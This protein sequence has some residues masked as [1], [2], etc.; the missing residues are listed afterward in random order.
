[1]KYIVYETTNLVNNKIYIGI[2][3]TVNPE[4][5]DNYIGCGCLTTQ[6]WTYMHPKTHFQYAVKKYG[7]KNFR[8]KTLAIFDTLEE[9]SN[10]EAELVNEK[11]LQ[12]SD[13]YNMILGGINDNFYATVKCYQYD[14]NGNFIK[15]YESIKQASIELNCN[16]SLI[17]HA[18][19]LKIK[20]KN[21][22]WTNV[23]YDKLDITE[24]NLRLNH[25]VPIYVYTETGE[26]L[27]KFQN[28]IQAAKEIGININSIKE[29]CIFGLLKKGFYFCEVKD[30]NYSKAR[31]TYIENR[32][33]YKYDGTTNKFLQEYK[34]QIDAEKEY[35]D[36]NI[37]KA[38]KLKQLCINNFYW[39]L[40][41]LDLFGQSIKNKKRQ[42]GQYDLS[43]NLL[44]I[45]DSATAAANENGTSVWKVLNGTNKSQKGCVYKYLT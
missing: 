33:I 42:V 11:F 34:H 8:R 15:E 32:P 18:I 20:G 27:T 26:Y 5:F 36:S 9:A 16:H 17:G 37:N 4:V 30:K 19:A 29:A 1:M 10:L 38:I 2:H 40:E 12:R 21:S 6:P 7:P 45:Y 35:P 22:F 13:V 41:K 31:K 23:K 28:Q 39:S 44:K 25:Q 14:L 43:G 3:K 24:F